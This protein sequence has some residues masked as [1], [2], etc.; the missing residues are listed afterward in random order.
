VNLL[1]CGTRSCSEE[2][3]LPVLFDTRVHPRRW[4]QSSTAAA[5]LPSM[6]LVASSSRKACSIVSLRSFHTTRFRGDAWR[7]IRS[8]SSGSFG[9]SIRP[10][11][12]AAPPALS[13][14]AT[15]QALGVR[16]SRSRPGSAQ[17]DRTGLSHRCFTG[18]QHAAPG[19]RGSPRKTTRGMARANASVD[20]WHHHLA[21]FSGGGIVRA[22]VLSRQ[23]V[24]ALTPRLEE[25]PRAGDETTTRRKRR[26]ARRR[27]VRTGREGPN[28]NVVS[29]EKVS[30]VGPGGVAKSSARLGSGR[31]VVGCPRCLCCRYCRLGPWSSWRSEVAIVA[32]VI[33]DA[34]AAALVVLVY[35][36]LGHRQLKGGPQFAFHGGLRVCFGVSA[37]PGRFVVEARALGRF[38]SQMT[39]RAREGRRE[40]VEIHRAVSKM[41]IR[42]QPVVLQELQCCIALPPT[43]VAHEVT[44]RRGMIQPPA[45]SQTWL[46]H[47]KANPAASSQARQSPHKSQQFLNPC[48]SQEL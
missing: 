17:E 11:V 3:L 34:I 15:E 28:K 12:G 20:L 4:N 38:S 9:F 18:A 44:V 39:V 1:S 26:T 45:P 5:P 8:P 16:A 42:H 46:R 23:V 37:K 31:P 13:P 47:A 24:F 19:R 43:P 14:R 30:R 22:L 2:L 36:N 7:G 48:F 27:R 40:K 29:R 10:R 33:A 6:L 25:P 41:S 21:R 32:V 35:A